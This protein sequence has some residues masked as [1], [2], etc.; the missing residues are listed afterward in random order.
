MLVHP[1]MQSIMQ[2]RTCLTQ[3]IMQQ[4]M[5]LMVDSHPPDRLTALPAI[6]SM[7]PSC[8]CVDLARQLLPGLALSGAL[9]GVGCRLGGKDLADLW[10]S[11]A[12]D[13][14]PRGAVLAKWLDR[15]PLLAASGSVMVMG[16]GIDRHVTLMTPAQV[17]GTLADIQLGAPSAMSHLMSACVVGQCSRRRQCNKVILLMLLGAI[18]NEVLAGNRGCTIWGERVGN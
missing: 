4:G 2:L 10:W 17:Q 13:A 16:S 11:R 7:S 9:A 12:A 14:L 5:A 6:L 15:L 8:A 3:D 1:N 18:C